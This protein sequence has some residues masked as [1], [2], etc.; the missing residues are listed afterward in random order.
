MRELCTHTV[1]TWS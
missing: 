1:H